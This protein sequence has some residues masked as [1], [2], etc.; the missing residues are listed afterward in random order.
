[1]PAPAGRGTQASHQELAI[2]LQQAVTILPASTKRARRR[3]YRRLWVRR[4]K[5]TGADLGSSQAC[6]GVGQ[7]GSNSSTLPPPPPYDALPRVKAASTALPPLSCARARSSPVLLPSSYQKAPPAHTALACRRL[8]ASSA[9]CLLSCAASSSDPLCAS[10]LPLADV[11]FM[12]GR[13]AAAATLRP[14]IC[15]PLAGAAACGCRAAAADPFI[16]FIVG[17]EAL[18]PVG[19]AG[20]AATPIHLRR[21]SGGSATA[22]APWRGSTA[23]Q[24]AATAADHQTDAVTR[25]HTTREGAPSALMPTCRDGV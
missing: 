22:K 14:F 21:G 8:T 12:R 6:F 18:G 13:P 15:K 20:R 7:P 5:E 4:C 3:A 23:R 24:D 19:G 1:M 10:G 9:L 17:R 25:F 16:P 2:P 11:P